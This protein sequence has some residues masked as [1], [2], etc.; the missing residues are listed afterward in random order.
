MPGVIAPVNRH[1]PSRHRS[2][3]PWI[4]AVML[5]AF[6]AVIL[7][8]PVLAL[9]GSG[10]ARPEALGAQSVATPEKQAQQ[11][12]A[13]D[14]EDSVIESR[15]VGMLPLTVLDVM[16]LAAAALSLAGFAIAF[17]ALSRPRRP[18]EDLSAQAAPGTV[19]AVAEVQ[20]QGLPPSGG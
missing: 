3:A 20:R 7:V 8:V 5:V 16:V 2:T 18:V 19:L 9:A 11:P 1:V 14:S 4:A 15:V 12:Q 6:V 10:P 17:R 13:G